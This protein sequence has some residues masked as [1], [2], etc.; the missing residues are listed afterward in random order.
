[1]RKRSC[2]GSV[3]CTGTTMRYGAPVDCIAMPTVPGEPP[4]LGDTAAMTPEQG[5]A[6]F[7]RVVRQTS[8]ATLAGVPS[9][10]IPAGLSTRTGLPV[11]LMLEGPWGSDR[12]LLAIARRI[13]ARLRDR[14]AAA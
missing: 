8:P 2:A 6:L 13:D 5:A 10:S 14:A 11:G 12:R 9:V 3:S 4:S 7:A 1:M